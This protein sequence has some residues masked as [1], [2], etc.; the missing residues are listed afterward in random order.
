MHNS[1]ELLIQHRIREYERR[2]RSP[3]RIPISASIILPAATMT[4]R[5]SVRGGDDQWGH[6][7]REMMLLGF[8]IVRRDPE[9]ITDIIGAISRGFGSVAERANG[10]FRSK[11]QAGAA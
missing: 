9:L 7:L 5:L 4:A 3:R 8:K 10:P 1:L 11:P 6:W 2:R